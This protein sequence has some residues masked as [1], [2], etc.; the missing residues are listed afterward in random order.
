MPVPEIAK[1]LGVAYVVEGS[2]RKQ[3]TKVRITAQLIKAADGFHVWSD[4]FTR[5]LK[6]IFAVQ[7]EIAGLI[8]KNLS[9][10]MGVAPASVA[11]VNPE[12]YQRLLQ[13]RFYNAQ[14][15]YDGWR[16]SIEECKAALAIDPDFALAAAELARGYIHLAR[17]GGIRL[18]EGFAA[19]R[20]AAERALALNPNLPEAINAMAWVQRTV[21]WDWSRAAAGFRRAYELAPHDA[22]MITSLAVMENNLG[23]FDEAVALGRRAV[24]LDPINA[25]PL[26]YLGIFLAWAG[27]M[28]EAVTVNRRAIELAPGATEWH[29][30]Q[31]RFLVM[32]GRFDAAAAAADLESSERYR[33]FA[34][35][36]VRLAQ[37]NRPEADKLRQELID[38]FGGEIAFNVAE[39]YAYAGESDQAFAWLERARTQHETTLI[40]LQGMPTLRTLHADPRWPAFLKKMG[41]DVPE[42]KP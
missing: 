25:S 22:A 19:G 41:Y 3:G 6:D 18:D 26:A 27:Q 40:W 30:Y 1:Q 17:F 24:E 21:D 10:K 28:D 9:L 34:R 20:S 7:D 11:I 36:L 16:K 23:H 32:Q 39:L 2:V 31:V 38:R 8:A 5:E 35:A 42:K 33:A 12:A 37:K 14:Q 13:A 15:D 4:T 29:S